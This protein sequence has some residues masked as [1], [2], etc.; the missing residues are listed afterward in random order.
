[1]IEQQLSKILGKVPFPLSINDEENPVEVYYNSSMVVMD[2][3]GGV[4]FPC[5]SHAHSSYEFLIPITSLAVIKLEQNTFPVEFNKLMPINPEQ[6]HGAAGCYKNCNCFGWHIDDNFVKSIANTMYGKSEVA[7]F[8]NF[9][10][11]SKEVN[12]LLGWFMEEYKH[13]HA[14][15]SFA[16]DVL[17]TQLTITLLRQ[18]KN[19]CSY[20]AEKRVSS[21]NPNIERTIEYLHDNYQA[22]FYLQDIARI[23]NLSP[24]HFLR[25]FKNQT[26]KTPYAYLLD[27]KIEKA[28]VLLRSKKHTVT[29][30]CFLCGFNNTS[31]FA[32]LFK[33]KVGLSPSDYSKL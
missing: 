18:V 27:I 33:R 20:I 12:S 29:E 24:Y 9:I 7:F 17:V 32:T 3:K 22:Q 11:V 6:A 19:S 23:A 28:K 30:V 1:M 31:H 25:L 13:K 4:D 16:L 21:A 14:G 10:P 2:T 15:M 8:N 26:G 5:D